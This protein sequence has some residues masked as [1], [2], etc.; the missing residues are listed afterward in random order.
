MAA[1]ISD[2]CD[3]QIVLR[4][5]DLTTAEPVSKMLGNT[6]I[7]T[8]SIN[9]SSN[10]RG[11]SSGMNYSMQGKLLID[12]SEIKKM[13]K[14]KLILFQT[15]ENPVLLDKYFYFKQDRWKD[16]EHTSWINEMN[17]ESFKI[18]FFVL[19]EKSTEPEEVNPEE[20]EENNIEQERSSRQEQ[21]EFNLF[22]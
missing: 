11:S 19:E 6:T 5:N 9:E 14:N 3:N 13:P 8:N 2:S 21:K 20:Q 22:A 12:P 4:A 10:D 15:N 16:I 1:A 17:R 7:L 18:H